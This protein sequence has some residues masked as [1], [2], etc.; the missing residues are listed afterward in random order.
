MN[1]TGLSG[2][3]PPAQRGM[4]LSDLLGLARRLEMAEALTGVELAAV[5]R[6]SGAFPGAT[7]LAVGGGY[8]TYAGVG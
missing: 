5:L 4:D 1:S 8:A 7:S 6:Q 2:D 3:S